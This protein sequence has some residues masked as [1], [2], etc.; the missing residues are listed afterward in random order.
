[1]TLVD[2][3]YLRNLPGTNLNPDFQQ[4]SMPICQWQCIFQRITDSSIQPSSSHTTTVP[5]RQSL[6]PSIT[7]LHLRRLLRH[8]TR[9]L[10]DKNIA[11]LQ[12]LSSR[13]HPVVVQL[14]VALLFQL[15]F[16]FELRVALLFETGLSG[17]RS[18]FG[19]WNSGFL[20]DADDA[21]EGVCVV[22]HALDAEG[23][24][25]GF[26]DWTVGLGEGKLVGRMLVL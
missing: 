26:F 20:V 17:A 6:N 21:C 16:V 23:H 18:P 24:V 2:L 9:I 7:R 19:F 4:K 13:L 10:L 25:Q 5:R 8:P 3:I 1:M 22:V 12:L 11:D 15:H 14:L